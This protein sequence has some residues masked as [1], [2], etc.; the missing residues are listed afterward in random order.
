MRLLQNTAKGLV[1]ALAF[2]PDGRLLAAGSG[3]FELHP[4]AGGPAFSAPT[5]KGAN[6]VGLAIDQRRGWLFC[7]FHDRRF[8]V[9]QI[10]GT[11]RGLPGAED[12][13]NVLALAIS[14]DGGRL[15]VSRGTGPLYGGKSNRLE[16]WLVEGWDDWRLAWTIDS[17]GL[18]GEGPWKYTFS[19][20]TAPDGG[21]VAVAGRRN[22]SPGSLTLRDG[23][24]GALRR[25]TILRSSGFHPS[26]RFTEDGRWL[27]LMEE[28]QLSAWQVDGL[29]EISSTH[30]PG[31]GHFRSL[32]MHPSCRFLATTAGDGVVRYWHPE[33]LREL[34][35]FQW[36]IG[37][38]SAIAFSPDGTL[39]AVGG[40][41]G[42][43]AVWDIDD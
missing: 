28:S 27:V 15:F 33:G 41:K 21:S 24:T 30:A 13:Q 35:S 37:K 43:I 16:C 23:A 19:L 20:A 32:A 7:Y 11:S 18:P 12:D 25:E 2:L 39:G 38:L 8:R 10:D 34:R 22:L 5:F 1:T 42:R 9:F 14:P 6:L 36:G 4:L 3:S 31:R 40:E 17:N 29:R 26:L